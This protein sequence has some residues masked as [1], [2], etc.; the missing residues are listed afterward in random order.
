MLYKKIRP[1][2]GMIR[3]PF[4]IRFNLFQINSALGK[5]GLVRVAPCVTW[6]RQI[7]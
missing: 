1:P 7:D 3:P 4:L 6:T 2:F 5:F